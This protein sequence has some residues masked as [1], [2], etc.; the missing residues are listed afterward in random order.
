MSISLSCKQ[1]KI[2][3]YFSRNEKR[4]QSSLQRS[5]TYRWLQAM[6]TTEKEEEQEKEVKQN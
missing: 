6:Q 1:I 4:R 2:F 5:Q 3:E